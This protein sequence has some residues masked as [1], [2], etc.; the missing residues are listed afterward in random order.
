MIFPDYSNLSHFFVVVLSKVFISCSNLLQLWNLKKN[1]EIE[2]FFCCCIILLNI[3]N[4][5]RKKIYI[6][7]KR[8]KRRKYDNFVENLFHYNFSVFRFKTLR[9]RRQTTNDDD[10]DDDERYILLTFFVLQLLTYLLFFS[11]FST[12]S[13]TLNFLHFIIK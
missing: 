7:K 10:D 8:V 11:S 13:L 9:Q 3:V 12:H 1:R 4:E 6:Y 5:I 2:R